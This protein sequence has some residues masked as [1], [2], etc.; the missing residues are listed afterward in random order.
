MFGY[1][2]N[3][4]TELVKHVVKEHGSTDFK[5]VILTSDEV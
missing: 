5:I 3:A 4:Y 2:D 1:A